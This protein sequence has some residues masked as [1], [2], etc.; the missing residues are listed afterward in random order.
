MNESFF[1]FCAFEFKKFNAI[2]IICILHFFLLNLALT[3]ERAEVDLLRRDFWCSPVLAENSGRNDR[4]ARE[5]EQDV[6]VLVEINVALK[7]NNN[8]SLM[9]AYTYNCAMHFAPVTLN[10]NLKR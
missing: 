2:I 7:F 5:W 8:G 6:N 3:T 9:C 10:N 1:N 4:P